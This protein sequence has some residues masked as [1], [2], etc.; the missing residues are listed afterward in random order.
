L[1]FEFPDSRGSR[2]RWL[3]KIQSAAIDLE[4]PAHVLASVRFAPRALLRSRRADVALRRLHSPPSVTSPTR[5]CGASS[6]LASLVPMR[7]SLKRPLGD[8][9]QHWAKCRF[10]EPLDN[11]LRDDPDALVIDWRIVATADRPLVGFFSIALQGAVRASAYRRSPVACAESRCFGLK[12]VLR[13]RSPDRGEPRRRLRESGQLSPL[14]VDA[15]ST[16]DHA[17][18]Q[19][20]VFRRRRG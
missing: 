16:A 5:S 20:N 18:A 1:T 14:T 11:T 3:C 17:T 6:S 10:P 13:G 4:L 19:Q 7:V 8:R 9:D 12:S 15:A 2:S